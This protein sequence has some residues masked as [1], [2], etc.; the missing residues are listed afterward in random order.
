M[1]ESDGRGAVLPIL[2]REVTPNSC[3]ALQGIATF[4][5]AG[6]VPHI[7]LGSGTGECLNN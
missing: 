7:S 5:E 1:F 3:E 4:P 6:S 2:D